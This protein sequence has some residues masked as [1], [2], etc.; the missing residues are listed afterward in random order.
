MKPSDEKP[1]RREMQRRAPETESTALDT[2]QRHDDVA[3]WDEV[4]EMAYDPTQE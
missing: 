3:E 4:D 1:P 2:T